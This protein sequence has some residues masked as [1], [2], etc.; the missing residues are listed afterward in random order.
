MFKQCASTLDIVILL[1]A[2]DTILVDR[3]NTRSKQH[4]VKGKSDR[5]AYDFLENYRTSFDQILE[6]LTSYGELKVLHFDADR[7]SIDQIAAEVLT[8]IDLKHSESLN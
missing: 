5:E 8:A 4:A 2:P 3:I 7:L 1:D 6:R